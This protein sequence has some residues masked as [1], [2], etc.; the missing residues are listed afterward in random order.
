MYM[1]LFIKTLYFRVTKK[2]TLPRPIT[3]LS[4]LDFSGESTESVNETLATIRGLMQE[5]ISLHSFVGDER[6]EKK[7]TFE[8]PKKELLASIFVPIPGLF[9][10]G[11]IGSIVYKGSN[12]LYKKLFN[13]F[14]K[15]QI[16][17][18]NFIK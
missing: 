1:L 10:I 18:I 12:E 2:T 15:I 14:K 4:I 7:E 6:S 13:K 11:L 3:E 16:Q 17:K 9:E 8:F 5:Y